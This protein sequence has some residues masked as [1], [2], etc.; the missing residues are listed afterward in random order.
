MKKY[1]IYCL[2]AFTLTAM[3]GFETV[4]V[5]KTEKI[6][7]SNSGKLLN[8]WIDVHLKLIRTTKG[9]S[10]GG[11]FRHLGYSSVALYES[12]ISGEK[13]YATLAGQL[14]GLEPLPVIASDKNVCW[15]ASANAAMAS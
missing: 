7:D 9:L 8:D 14:Q 3:S 6:S 5:S 15:Q 13:N 4:T 10:Q 1:W 12:I 11:I 2:L